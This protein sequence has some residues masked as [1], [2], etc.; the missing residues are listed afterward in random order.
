M[1]NYPMEKPIISIFFLILICAFFRVIDIFVLRLDEPPI[2][3]IILS[4]S[5]GLLLLFLYLRMIHSSLEEIG[6]HYNNIFRSIFISLIFVALGVFIIYGNQ[7]IYLQAKNAKPY[8]AFQHYTLLAIMVSVVAGNII[9][10]LMEEGLFRGLMITRIMNYS[11][12]WKVNILQ[13][14]IFGIWHIVWPLKD[15]Y[16]SKVDSIGTLVSMSVGNIIITFLMGLTM[17]YI[18]YKTGNLWTTISWHFFMNLVQ[19][20]L[21]VRSNNLNID[22]AIINT[23]STAVNGFSFILVFIIINICTKYLL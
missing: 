19:N 8:L 13:A 4:K 15:F 9:N 16:I 10:A 18:F 7:F 6:F 3:E 21:V 5:I 12:F 14:S 22:A 23:S 20:I 2:S 1:T 17:G 11:T